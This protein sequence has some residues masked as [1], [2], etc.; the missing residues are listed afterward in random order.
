MLTAVLCILFVLLFVYHT[1]KMF[2][3]G[4]NCGMQAYHEALLKRSAEIFQ[5]D[6]IKQ[7]KGE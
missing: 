1:F 6:K 3:W 5:Q 4:F 7:P 2:V